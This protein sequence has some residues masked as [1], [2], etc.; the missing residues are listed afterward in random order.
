MSSMHLPKQRTKEVNEG[1]AIRR[2]FKKA[3]ASRGSGT[4]DLR[5]EIMARRVLVARRK[6][7][8]LAP[9]AMRGY[10]ATSHSKR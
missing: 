9:T 1:N 7:T 8:T 4:T 6:S 5:Q 10:C 3:E 2:C